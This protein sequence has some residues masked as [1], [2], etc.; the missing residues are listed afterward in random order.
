MIKEEYSPY[1]IIHSFDKLIQFKDGEQPNPLQVQI[2]PSNKCNNSCLTCAYRLKGN[3]SNEIFN[4][5]DLLS[6]EKIVETL[7]SCV[8]MGVR[9]IQI[10]GGG[11]PLVHPKI[12]NIFRDILD[13]KLELALVS[14]GMALDDELCKILSDSAWVRISVDCA[15]PE[16]YS[17]FRKVNKKMFFRTIENIKNLVKY[18][19][20]SVIGAGFVVNKYN[21]K[22]IFDAAKLFKEI[23]VDN[24]RISAAFT[25][26]GY[27]YFDGIYE[28]SFELAKK[29]QELSDD[30]FTV[31]NLFND[32]M[33][34]MFEG[35]QDYNFCPTKDLLAYVGADYNVYTCCTLAYNKKGK[36]G[37]I[38]NQSFKD[39]WMSDDKINM[40][41]SHNPDLRCKNPC[42]YKAK[43]EF[44]NYCIKDKPKHINFI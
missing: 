38:K 8:D 32:R 14:N 6:Y 22:E 20:D 11:E 35:V 5:K 26:D 34:D 27:S 16:T 28:D 33:K 9:A 42:L 23:G 17:S 37:S 44:I 36:I 25:P 31:F 7:D 18:K 30:N 39:L 43:N 4:D 10:T 3:K 21:Y 2:I 41:K 24:F 12:K 15:T 29:A 13:R 19:K 40:F 1:K